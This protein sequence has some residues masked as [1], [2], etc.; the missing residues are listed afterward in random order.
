VAVKILR[1][2]GRVC[3]ETSTE[4]ARIIV[5][6]LQGQITVSVEITGMALDP[7][8]YYVDVGLFE[9]AWKHAYDHH[10]WVYPLV[11][12]RAI[13]D[14]AEPEEWVPTWSIDSGPISARTGD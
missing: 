5:P 7:G 2:D 4:A 3:Y 9:R 6:T 10:S 13:G 11:V 12:E 14:R 1:Q 8:S